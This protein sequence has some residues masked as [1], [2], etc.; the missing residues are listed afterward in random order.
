[1][2][3]FKKGDRVVSLVPVG[4]NNVENCKGTVIDTDFVDITVLFDVYIRG[5][6]SLDDI[7]NGRAWYCDKEDLKKIIS[8]T[9]INKYYKK[10]IN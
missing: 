3:R 9:I 1:M 5:H 6:Y 7:K 2:R 8:H 10:V 4:S